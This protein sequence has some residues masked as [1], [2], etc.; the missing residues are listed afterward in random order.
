MPFQNDEGND[1]YNDEYNDDDN[2]AGETESAK[3]A[4]AIYPVNRA[5][6]LD[7]NCVEIIWWASSLV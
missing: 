2:A 5:K 1:E 7:F 4:P 3:S 6:T